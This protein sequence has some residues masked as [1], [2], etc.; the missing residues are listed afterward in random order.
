MTS[1]IDLI[2]LTK[3]LKDTIKQLKKDKHITRHG[4]LLGKA[5]KLHHQAKKYVKSL[6]KHGPDHKRTQRVHR[7]LRRSFDHFSRILDRQI[8]RN[9]MDDI[10]I[11]QLLPLRDQI[12][13][14][15]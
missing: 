15:I 11:S 9:R 12:D 8:E 14:A 5:Q 13:T 6:D 3:Q 1:D 2:V 10:G 4:K 7:Q